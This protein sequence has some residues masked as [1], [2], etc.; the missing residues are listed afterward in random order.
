L[1]RAARTL[2]V[3]EER[4]VS[5]ERASES[6]RERERERERK[7]HLFSFILADKTKAS[8]EDVK[9]CGVVRLRAKAGR[10]RSLAH[11]ERGCRRR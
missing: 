8:G 10:R 1:R 7:I 3:T 9:G 6:Q 4:Y 11:T 2:H 5:G